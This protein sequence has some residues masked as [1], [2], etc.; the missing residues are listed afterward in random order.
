MKAQVGELT[1]ESEEIVLYIER[2]AVTS[3]MVYRPAER[4]LQL[5]SEA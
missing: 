2:E 1:E 5:L 4:S 3:R